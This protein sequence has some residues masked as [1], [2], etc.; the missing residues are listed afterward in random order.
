MLLAAL[1]AGRAAGRLTRA[2]LGCRPSHL[3][4]YLYK[5]QS[6]GV[7]DYLCNRLYGLPEREVERYLSQVGAGLVLWFV[8][9]AHQSRQSGAVALAGGCWLSVQHPACCGLCVCPI[10]ADKVEGTSRRWVLAQCAASGCLPW[11]VCASHQS[12]ESGA[13]ARMARCCV[14]LPLPLLLLALLPLLHDV[15]AECRRCSCC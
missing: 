2:A 8:C 4:S 11:L 13:V 12:R 14:L 7:R 15:A 10:K 1:P 5:S 3:R 9:A 6:A